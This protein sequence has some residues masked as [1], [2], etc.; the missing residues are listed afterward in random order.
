L[1]N[2]LPSKHLNAY[3][4]SV[5][6]LPINHPDFSE[7]AVSDKLKSIDEKRE[8]LLRVHLIVDFVSGM[9][10]QFAMDMY[11]MLKGIKVM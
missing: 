9:T 8:W 3:K 6:N 4:T 2:R 11:Q 1:F 5:I 10:D 7:T